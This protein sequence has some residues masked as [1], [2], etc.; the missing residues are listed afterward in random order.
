VTFDFPAKID[1][2]F[3]I[4]LEDAKQPTRTLFRVPRVI[5]PLCGL[6]GIAIFALG[7]YAGLA[8][9]EQANENLLPTLIY[10]LFWIGLAFPSALLGDV[11]RPFNPWLAIARGTGWATRRLAPTGSPSRCATPNASA[12]GRPSSASSASHGSSSST[13]TRTTR[14]SSRSSPSRTPPSSLSP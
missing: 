3:V 4:E 7:I 8:G 2:G 10:V 6:V 14:P 12:A 5:E 9:S 13:P 11:I 1:G